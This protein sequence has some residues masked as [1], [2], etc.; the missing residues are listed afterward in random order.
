MG[1]ML[2]ELLKATHATGDTGDPNSMLGTIQKDRQPD[3]LVP[4]L[5]QALDRNPEQEVDT[6]HAAEFMGLSPETVRG[7]ED[8]KHQANLS[9]I[10]EQT[11]DAPVT[12]SFLS[13]P[14]NS[15]IAHDDVENLVAIEQAGKEVTGENSS[16]FNARR[17]WSD[18]ETAEQGFFE[19][20]GDAFT[21][22]RLTHQLGREGYGASQEGTITPE[23]QRAIDGIQEAMK[24]RAYED[25][26]VTG[27]F[28]SAS[29]IVGQ[30]LE[31]INS[32]EAALSVTAGGT[33]GGVAGTLGG[34]FAFVT[35][36]AGTAIGAGVGLTGFMATD[37][38]I[39]ESGHAYLEFVDA[40]IEQETAKYMA[41]GIGL[42]NAG[43]EMAG[44]S[45]VAAPLIKAANTKLRRIFGEVV[46]KETVVQAAKNFAG[47][48]A[49]AIGV[50]TATEVLQEGTVIAAREIAAIYDDGVEK[51]SDEEIANRLT[52]V[53]LKTFKGMAVLGFAGSGAN[54]VTE[55]GQAKRA[56]Q[57][58]LIAKKLGELV[59]QS[60]LAQR[61]PDA[62]AEHVEAAIH[63]DR[64]TMP[65]QAFEE[66]IA[67]APFE[68]AE[69]IPSE[70]LQEFYREATLTGGDVVMS[71][72]N[73]VRKIMI[74]NKEMYEKYREHIR[75][76]EGELTASEAKE[77]DETAIGQAIQEAGFNDEQEG[78]NDII[79]GT[80]VSRDTTDAA[81]DRKADFEAIIDTIP[82]GVSRDTTEAAKARREQF[83]AIIADVK[84]SDTTDAAKARK[85]AF[86]AILEDASP[87]TTAAA[88][89]R[90][91]AF[92]AI[93]KLSTSPDATDAAVNRK[94][95]FDAIEKLSTSPDA[96]DAAVN[97][98]A[99]FDAIE[100]LSTSPDATDAAVNRKA[101]FDAIEKLSTSPDATAAAK[102]RKAAF[103]AI[104]K[105]STSPDATAA[106]KDRKAAFE[107][108]L[109]DASPDTT[110]AS[111]NRREDAADKF[112]DNLLEHADSFGLNAMFKTADEAG[113]T[114]AQYKNY[115]VVLQR[116]VDD[117]KK[118]KEAAVLRREKR[119]LQQDIA[120]ER[121]NLAEEI[122]KTVRV[123]PLYQAVNKLQE[124]DGLD[125]QSIK[126]VFGEQ[127]ASFVVKELRSK[128]V[129]V[130]RV[131]LQGIHIDAYAD[132]HE[133][134]AG[135]LMVNIMRGNPTQQEVVAEEANRQVQQRFPE[136]FGRVAEL[137]ENLAALVH[138]RTDAVITA[139]IE[140]LSVDK[141]EKNLKPRLVR[142]YARRQMKTHKLRDVSVNR[143]LS[144]ASRFGRQAG[145]LLRAG[146]RGGARQAKVNQL[147]ALQYV[148]ESERL[149]QETV[150]G[151]RYLSKF[152]KSRRRWTSLAPGYLDGIREILD[153]FS[154]S[155]KLTS[156]KRTELE[157]FVSRLRDDGLPFNFPQRLLDDDKLN[158]KDMTHSE[159]GL[160]IERVKELE[161]LGR[162]KQ[163]DLNTVKVNETQR[164]IKSVV[165]ALGLFPRPKENLETRGVLRSTKRGLK[166]AALL[167]L[168]MDSTILD[169][170]V[171]ADLGPVYQSVK[172]S[173]DRS[174]TDGYIEGRPG[175]LNL[176]KQM[177]QDVIDLYASFTKAEM[178]SLSRP[179]LNVPGFNDPIS[180]NVQLSILLNMGNWDNRQALLDSGQFTQNQLDSVA[181]F[182]SDRDLAFAQSV[183]DYLDSYWTNITE[184]TERRRG[185][186]PE[187]VDAQA[188]E[189][190]GN[191]YA[192]GYYPLRYDNNKSISASFADPTK[193][194]DQMRYGTAMA[195][196]TKHDHTEERVGSGGKPVLL[197]LFALSSHLDM[198]A[199]DLEMGDAVNEA[200]RVIHSDPVKKAFQDAGK[201]ETWRAWDLWLGDTITGEMHRGG[202]VEGFLRYSRSGFTISKLA[203]NASTALLQPLGII[204]TSVAI[205]KRNTIKGLGSMLS[206]PWAGDN[207][208][209]KWIENQSNV[210]QQREET[211]NKD[212]ADSAR[213]LK[214][215]FLSRH[216]P[217]GTVE[218]VHATFFYALKKLQRFVDT[219]TWLAAYNAGMGNF[220]ND[221]GKARQ[222]ADRMVIRS[223]ASGNFQ[224]RT[225]LERGTVNSA[226]RQ[227]EWVRSFTALAS[228]FMAKTN[229][230]YT[231]TKRTNFRNPISIG[232]WLFDIMNLYV[233]EA[234]LVSI[235]RGY[236]PD[237]DDDAGDVLGHIAGEGVNS[238]FAGVPLVR[239]FV[240]EAAGFRG[241]G[242]FGA[243][244][245]DFG[246]ATEQVAQGEFDEALFKSINNIGGTLFKYPS[247]QI[248]KT[249]SAINRAADGEDVDWIEFLVGPSYQKYK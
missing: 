212:I 20:L 133:F 207:S 173:I 246:K 154:L 146:D 86:E 233:V 31:G 64:I 65:I 193:A 188:F 208:V 228:Y 32:E 226:L 174:V 53:A 162:Q 33:A 110:D 92:D 104:E 167:G 143:Y 225:A 97:R 85:A 81:K 172:Q 52:E 220:V 19:N 61:D 116:R 147:V 120:T 5:S 78:G 29:E 24:D 239:E 109:A 43:L 152:Y 73:F 161:K 122:D 69:L 14:E 128:G 153:R 25:E 9:S 227:T 148:K 127:E 10:L 150:R 77:F 141:K 132:L 187:K 80:A 49:L 124:T 70:S 13:E 42:I 7:N 107:A 186:K 125:Q 99:A 126:N 156:K 23:R 121:A 100:K 205:G 101:A 21:T 244:I 177:S 71:T 45:A 114:P 242:T 158:Y 113:M 83:E 98:K 66:L 93:E 192:G 136:V 6:R 245:G 12:Q 211:W 229:V 201:V 129:K 123:R 171:Q 178:N 59:E 176:Q 55:I 210:M 140:A 249:V 102:D 112:P 41:G 96:T 191:S 206:Q 200:Y 108:I 235:L 54:F 103:E 15:S 185:F 199:Y 35:V 175:L 115:Q 238:L 240:S 62:V 163:E 17:K 48:Y 218:F 182:S 184:A 58:D 168:N 118:R 57:R 84:S 131:N 196:H 139:E 157:T 95:A 27:F 221:V 67:E 22:G 1:Q 87:D 183:W 209:F 144:M 195:S 164:R 117:S 165:D 155:P 189:V 159:F 94:A 135:N 248:N 106:A 89:D 4:S 18:R 134:G 166:E 243:L 234:M 237:E 38:Y 151:H 79:S 149:R 74:D 16:F 130:A 204:Q 72:G 145:R 76:K 119:A 11:K 3:T 82:D 60:K 46:K 40:G 169:L 236:W 230:A 247:S 232:N 56:K 8:I 197:D 26:G 203:W 44:V 198:V 34:P 36:P 179:N 75:W 180:R 160:T 219:W 91:A 213:L 37:A 39:T 137:E 181:E 217:E 51:L 138:D 111:K 170:D 28:A 190:R 142:E 88:K 222:Y 214:D 215:S 68:M 241:G 2:D 30:M 216:T 202:V 47:S 105:L 90:K 63:S 194:I 50:E 223:Q 231:R 224:E